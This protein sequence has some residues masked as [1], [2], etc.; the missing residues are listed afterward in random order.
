MTEF[1]VAVIVETIALFYFWP[2][3][4][5]RR[6][7]FGNPALL[8]D[9]P[10]LRRCFHARRWTAPTTFVLTASVVLLH[11]DTL[12]RLL[13]DLVLLNLLILFVALVLGGLLGEI[14]GD[15]F[16]HHPVQILSPRERLHA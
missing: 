5:A 7:G 11:I 4:M 13:E 15:H 8:S 2:K 16:R 12:H 6:S 9:N 3:V 14:V 10:H 1:I